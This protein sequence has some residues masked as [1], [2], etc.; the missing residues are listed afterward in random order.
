MDRDETV[1]VVSPGAYVVSD[2]AGDIGMFGGQ[3]LFYRD[4]RHLSKFVLRLDGEPLVPVGRREQGSRIDFSPAVAGNGGIRVERRRALGGGMEEEIMLYNGTGEIVEVR[5]DLEFD[6]DF[7]D[8][9][10]VRGYRRASDRGEVSREV[11]DGVLYFSYRREDFR[12]GT[13]VRVSGEG[14][15]P[16]VE[17]GNVSVRLRAGA[18]ETRSLRVSVSLEEGGAGVPPGEWKTTLYGEVPVLETGWVDLAGVW[19]Q[20]LEDLRTLA[21]DVGGG[22]RVPAAGAPWYM[23]LFGR[24]ALITAYQTMLLGVE[25][26]KNTLRALARYQARD[27]DDFRDSEPGKIPHEIR[28]GELA[29]FGEVPHSPYY[30]TADATPLFLIMLEE[31]W[32]WTADVELVRELERPARRAVNWLLEKISSD[33][34]G[35]IDYETRSAAG[36]R[37]HGWKDSEDSLLFRN[38]EQAETPI[39]LCEVQGYAYEALMRAAALSEYAW[40]DEAFAGTLRGEAME[41]KAR[42]DRDFWMEDRSYY[43]LALDGSG[44]RVDSITSNAGHLLW[45]GIVPEGKARNVVERLLGPELFSGWGVRTMAVGEEG[46][47]PT[48]YHNGSIWPHDNA[49]ISEGLRRYGFRRE[50]GRIAAALVEA[51]PYFGQRLPE[52]FGGYQREGGAGP[53][54]MPRS[55]SP[56]AW[57]AGTAPSLVRTML[58]LDPDPKNRKLATD[59]S[60]GGNVSGLRLSGVTAFGNQHKVEG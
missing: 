15:E 54:E 28:H 60:P 45:S 10:A 12:R 40:G 26:A 52:V 48:S 32:R 58:G 31:V 50:A 7:E 18:G 47:D 56:Q 20:S 38:G 35:Y 21:F 6:A 39:S 46:Y 13:E 11:E 17:P 37:N 16:V 27:Y 4:T 23:A 49:L 53:V 55:C 51:A 1:N 42:F 9:F 29:H 44:H 34:R 25:P 24:D 5:V 8:I 41:L 57:A 43:A 33:E 19:R 3:G 36:L 2:G 30:G 59:L 22:L 14:M